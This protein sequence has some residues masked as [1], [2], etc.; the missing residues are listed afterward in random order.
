MPTDYTLPVRQSV[1]EHLKATL[2]TV[3]AAQVWGE[4]IPT[5]PAY[6]LVWLDPSTTLPYEAQGYDG[7]EH[8]LVLHVFA[9]G[10]ATDEA[11]AIAAEIVE[12]MEQYTAPGGTGIVDCQWAN[13]TLLRDPANP[14]VWH[15]PVA[16]N[17]TV[18]G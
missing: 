2:A 3:P 11:L 17:V 15:V 16:F 1:V 6:P 5:N 8:N 12:V 10:P 13:T 4:F 14:D 9:A 18:A 7:S